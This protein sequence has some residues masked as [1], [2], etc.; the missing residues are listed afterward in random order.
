MMLS[1]ITKMFD[2]IANKWRAAPSCRPACRLAAVVLPRPRGLM[3]SC[4]GQM[5]LHGEISLQRKIYCGARL[6]PDCG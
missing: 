1:S 6:S 4:S 2:V 3:L 5:I